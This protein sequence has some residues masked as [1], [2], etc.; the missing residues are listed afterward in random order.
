[1]HVSGLVG[2]AV[3]GIAF[4]SSPGD[5]LRARAESIERFWY[6]YGPS[7]DMKVW[8]LDRS[9]GRIIVAK[10]TR[11]GP[12]RSDSSGL[13]VH[14]SQAMAIEAASLE[15]IE[16]QS[17]VAHW[18]LGT[19]GQAVAIPE[20]LPPR[21]QKGYVELRDI[22]LFHGIHVIL[23]L[24]SSTE[25]TVKYS[26]GASASPNFGEA[27]RKALEE[28]EQGHFLMEDNLERINSRRNLVDEIQDNYVTYNSPGTIHLWPAIERDYAD[29]PKAGS[30]KALEILSSLDDPPFAVSDNVFWDGVQFHVCRIFSDSWYTGLH[31][32]NRLPT[33]IQ[34]IAD[35]T[36]RTREYVPFG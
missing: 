2:N 1:M 4:G 18:S 8:R 9:K 30:Q 23:A 7:A 25:T 35:I 22:S 33:A 16:R 12:Y 32:T 36:R 34:S 10:D 31:D 13:A 5:N 14:T 11:K 17:L 26:A 24:Y 21:M 3:S 29:K 27:V 15:F 20:V 6:H 19:P 28:C